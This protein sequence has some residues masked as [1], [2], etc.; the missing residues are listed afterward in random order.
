LRRTR[1]I[2]RMP[3]SRKGYRFEL[4]VVP[5]SYKVGPANGQLD[6]IVGEREP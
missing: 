2:R 3:S 6:G 4:I 1:K 5:T